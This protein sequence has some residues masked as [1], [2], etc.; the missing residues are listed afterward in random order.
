MCWPEGAVGA[1]SLGLV[2]PL[3]ISREARTVGQSSL[4]GG[5]LFSWPDSK[6]GSEGL[7]GPCTW[8]VILRD[9]WPLGSV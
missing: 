9:E 2:W 8:D 3:R 1:E 7:T 5:S 4:V 6:A